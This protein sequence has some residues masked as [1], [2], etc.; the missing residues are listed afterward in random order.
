MNIQREFFDSMAEKWDTVC[1]HDM[2]RVQYIISLL[3]IDWGARILDVG[4]GTGVLIPLLAEQ[5]GT[6]GS[7]MAIDVSEKM[8][9]VARR[10]YILNNVTFVCDDVF[11]ADLPEASFD[12]V[13]CYSVFPHF[14]DKQSAINNLSRYLGIGGKLAICHSQSRE[15]INRLHKDASYAVAEDNLP[16][17]TVIKGYLSNADLRI[18]KEI[19]NE[20][21]YVVIGEK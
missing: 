11:K 21:M 10:K 2:N 6:E 16:S 3:N 15:A 14:K 8:L 17:L 9:E 19:D 7:I 1:Q 12:F 18:I 20:E 13:I 5:V 4:T